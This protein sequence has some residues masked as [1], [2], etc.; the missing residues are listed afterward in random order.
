MYLIAPPLGMLA[1][2]EVYVRGKGLKQVYCAKLHHQNSR[3]CIFRCRY[4]EL[5]HAEK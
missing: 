4:P 1:A 3:R 5:R 2:A